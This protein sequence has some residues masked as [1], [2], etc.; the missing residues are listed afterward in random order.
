MGFTAGLLPAIDLWLFY[1][2]IAAIG[3]GLVTLLANIT[4]GREAD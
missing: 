1:S 3:A 2:A 4:V